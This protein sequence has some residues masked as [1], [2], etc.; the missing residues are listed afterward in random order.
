[1]DSLAWILPLDY[2]PL[3]YSSLASFFFPALPAGFFSRSTSFCKFSTK[4][5]RSCKSCRDAKAAGCICGGALA[6]AACTTGTNSV[7]SEDPVLKFHRFTKILPLAIWGYTL[8]RLLYRLRALQGLLGALRRIALHIR[9]GRIR[10]CLIAGVARLHIG[11]IVHRAAPLFFR[12]IPE[13]NACEWSCF[14]PCLARKWPQKSRG[15]IPRLPYFFIEI[16]F[17]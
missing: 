9:S 6:G 11:G 15:N 5:C 17:P 10:L 13:N 4:S 16:K 8:H 3:D 14:G 2:L 7:K 1:M 12:I